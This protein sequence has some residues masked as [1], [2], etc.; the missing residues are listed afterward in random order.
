MTHLWVRLPGAGE[1]CLV[2]GWLSHLLERIN[3]VSNNHWQNSVSSMR[4]CLQYAYLQAT[5]PSQIQ[6][7]V[8]SYSLSCWVG[9]KWVFLG[10]GQVDTSCKPLSA[11][12]RSADLI[13]CLGRISDTGFQDQFN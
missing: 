5:H 6:D 11:C 4:L 7:A 1:T 9:R 3:I 8:V 2:A 12:P 13:I 10:W